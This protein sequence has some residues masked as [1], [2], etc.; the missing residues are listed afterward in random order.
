[1]SQ[2][3]RDH[4]I[5]L[6]RTNYGE[7]DRIIQFLT[8]EHGRIGAMA[9]GARREKS[10]LAGGIELFA[11]AE[12]NLVKG[13]K[14]AGELWTL[15]GARLSTFYDQIMT[16]YAR[17][18]TGYAVIKQIA[19]ATETVA[20]PEFFELLNDALANLNNLAI[21][22]RLTAAWF[23][24][25]LSSLLGVPLNTL[26]DLNG[27][28]LVEDARYDYDPVE[29]G[30]RFRENGQY[31]ADTIKFL[32]V[33]QANPPAVAARITE[34]HELLDGALNIARARAALKN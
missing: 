6:R 4:A 31:G 32:R 10:R 23:D 30:F 12:I 3:L 28:K 29:Q 2:T 17:L 20:P 24:L 16:D 34:A 25:K 14:N 18:Q 33:L 19:T 9:R 8:A 7:A 13:D 27:M 26:T 5:V 21:D 1:M 15:T 22:T 11:V